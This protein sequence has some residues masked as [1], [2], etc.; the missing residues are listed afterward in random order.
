M[1]ALVPQLDEAL[2]IVHLHKTADNGVFM[3]PATAAS[4]AGGLH[5]LERTTDAARA[6]EYFSTY[7][8]RQS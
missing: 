5:A 7:L 6:V 3:P 4:G 8:G 1:P 2:G